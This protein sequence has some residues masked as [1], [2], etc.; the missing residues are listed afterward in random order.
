MYQANKRFHQIDN[1]KI[2]KIK[3]S[4]DSIVSL[5]NEEQSIFFDSFDKTLCDGCRAGKKSSHCSMMCSIIECTLNKDIQ[6]CRTCQEFP[7][8]ELTDLQSK[9]THR[10]EIVE[11]KNHLTEIGREKWLI[12]MLSSIL[13]PSCWGQ[14]N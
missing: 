8:K 2:R 14:R 4:I 1:G 6:F 7:C 9:N 12:E 13:Q 11:S 5:T 10:V 3:N